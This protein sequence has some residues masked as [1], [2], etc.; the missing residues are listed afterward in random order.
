MAAVLANDRGRCH[1]PLPPPPATLAFPGL[2]PTDQC[3]PRPVPWLL[4]PSPMPDHLTT[5]RLAASVGR[6]CTVAAEG[7]PPDDALPGAWLTGLPVL[8]FCIPPQVLLN[9]H[10]WGDPQETPL[11]SADPA[12]E[13]TLAWEPRREARMRL[14]TGGDLFMEAARR[15]PMWP[16]GSPM[17]AI[18]V[19]G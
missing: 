1:P 10:T 19:P 7:H 12:G 4:T 14:G 16:R 9:V 15:G 18:T 5:S 11:S 3:F 13:A 8:W 17:N 6:G 2:H